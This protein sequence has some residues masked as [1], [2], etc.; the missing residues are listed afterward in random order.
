MNT[1][2]DLIPE[3]EAT[4]LARRGATR[5]GDEIV[6]CCPFHDEANAS[7]AFNAMK[8]AYTCHACGAK[9]GWKQ[10]AL[11]LGIDVPKPRRG[12]P[13]KNERRIVA[14]YPYRDEC[15][16]LLFEKVRYEPKQFTLRRSD[17]ADG[18]IY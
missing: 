13:P 16:Q 17:G 10:L 9:G 11:R 18:F 8:G 4:L 12:R 7:F 1:P 5:R 15:G 2:A 3:L 6:C 14:A